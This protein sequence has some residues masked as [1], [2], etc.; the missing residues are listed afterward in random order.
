MSFKKM[1]I[2]EFEKKKKFIQIVLFFIFLKKLSCI[3]YVFYRKQNSFDYENIKKQ[4]NNLS[5]YLEK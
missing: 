5:F 4:K 2:I 1:N 3:I